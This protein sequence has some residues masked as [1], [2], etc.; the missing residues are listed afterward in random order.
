[1]DQDNKKVIIKVENCSKSFNGITV[2]HDVSFDLLAGEVHCLCGENGAGKSTFIKIVSGAYF[3]DK[4]AVYIDG[5]KIK[6][7]EPDV[8]LKMGVETIYQNQFL[9]PNLSVAENIYMGDY[10]TRAGFVDYKG[11]QKKAQELIDELELE[12]DPAARVSD[13][14]VADRQTVQIARAMAKEAKVLMLDEPTA[15]YG[16]Q[17][18]RNLIRIVKQIAARGIGIIYISHHLE[19]VFE[20][21]DRV[22]V[23]RDGQ[24]I[25]CYKREEI[26]EAR[27]IRD[28]VG[29]DTNMFY[30]RGEIG[31]G[32]AGVLEVKGLYKEDYV[33]ECSFRMNRGEIV[34]F[35]GMVGSGRSELVS[36]IF[37][38]ERADGGD[39]TV[40]GVSVLPKD[41]NDAIRKGIG[42]ITEDRQKSG[43]FLGHSVGWNFVSAV[44]N[45]NKG[46]LI[47]QKKENKVFSK[48]IDK[49]AIKTK[50][51]DQGIQYLSG[52]NQQKVVLARWLYAGCDIVIF[53]EPTKGIDIGAKEDVYKLITQLAGEGKFIILVSSDMPELIAMSDRVLIMNN[54]K[55][56]GELTGSD[57]TEEQILSYSIGG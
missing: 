21:A 30:Q 26:D 20:L 22:T 51:A 16:R 54:K 11:L 18:K 38:A 33:S 28:M 19:E 8:A 17:E 4:G 9:M 24:K 43:M 40:D 6:H 5:K 45:K 29:R 56:A 53:D 2:F 13:L 14:D 50:G 35:G 12:L 48:Y 47:N 32:E 36:L 27:I 55:I 3:P 46:G 15:S 10:V 31:A 49:I 23:I 52:G 7:F 1:M 42:L 44:I 37:G 39:V 41:P 57:I 25:S 34:G